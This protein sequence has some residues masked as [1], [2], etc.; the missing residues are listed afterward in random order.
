MPNCLSTSRETSATRT[1]RCT[2]VGAATRTR[3]SSVS[4]SPRKRLGQLAQLLGLERALD[5]AVEDDAAVDRGDRD[6]AAR[7][8]LL[9]RLA[10]A[11]QVVLDHDLGAQ[12][13]LVVLVDRVQAGLA[14]AASEQVDD[15][16]RLGLHVGDLGIGDE[17]RG[18]GARQADHP[19]LAHLEAETALGRDGLRPSC[20]AAGAASRPTQQDRQPRA[21]RRRGAGLASSRRAP[22][23]KCTRSLALIPARPRRLRYCCRA[24]RGAATTAGPCA[25]RARRPGPR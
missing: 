11:G 6:P 17:H 20:P 10:Q 15:A 23:A 4:S 3:L 24:A 13:Q 14:G 7:Q 22:A 2:W 19:A 8:Q 5:L 1:R 18:G 21:R 9:D 16:R 25:G 12:Q